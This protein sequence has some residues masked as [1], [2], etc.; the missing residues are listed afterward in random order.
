MLKHQ[1]FIRE[2]TQWQLIK[3]RTKYPSLIYVAGT[4][5]KYIKSK[6]RHGREELQGLFSNS[7]KALPYPTQ[8]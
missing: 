3:H 5:Q 8:N 4:N 2:Q 6:F 7:H 1:W